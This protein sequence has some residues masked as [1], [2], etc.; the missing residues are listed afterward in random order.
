MQELSTT[1]IKDRFRVPGFEFQVPGVTFS[2][3]L[4]RQAA[5]TA[6][7]AEINEPLSCDELQVSC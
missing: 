1:F 5:E 7:T 4:N 2:A 3:R 6:E